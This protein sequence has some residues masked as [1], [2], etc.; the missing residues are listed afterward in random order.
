MELTGEIKSFTTK[1]IDGY[2]SIE[3]AEDVTFT[4]AKVSG[5]STLESLYENSSSSISYR[6]LYETSKSYLEN[7]YSYDYKIPTLDGANLTASLSN[8]S[9]GITYYYRLRAYVDGAYLYS[10]I[11]EF[12]TKSASD[13][14]STGEATDITMT[15]A[16]VTGITKLSEI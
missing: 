12:T 4:S 10:D 3:E 5:K 2:L 16:E 7:E 9:E 8:L 11:K 13:Y 6:F 15:T 14:L 1:S